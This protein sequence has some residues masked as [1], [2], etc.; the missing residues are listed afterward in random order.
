MAD[1]Q[2]F[3]AAWIDAVEATLAQARQL[4]APKAKA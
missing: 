3:P 4:A 2:Q 1:A